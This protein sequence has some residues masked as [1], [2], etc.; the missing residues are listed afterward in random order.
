MWLILTDSMFETK[1]ALWGTPSGVY[2]PVQCTP[3]PHFCA[4]W[5][6]CCYG[7]HTNPFSANYPR[8]Q[9]ASS[10]GGRRFRGHHL[11]TWLHFSPVSKTVVHLFGHWPPLSCPL[12]PPH[13]GGTARM[14]GL[15]AGLFFVFLGILC[16]R[17]SIG[18]VDRPAVDNTACRSSSAC[19]AVPIKPVPG[20]PSPPFIN[21][22]SSAAANLSSLSRGSTAGPASL[23]GCVDYRLSLFDNDSTSWTKSSRS[24]FLRNSV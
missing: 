22:T 3:C 10:K 24:Q 8:T 5:L 14:F 23:C 21:P 17:V 13:V 9:S 6:L 19:E 1:H 12:Q 7:C 15:N 18:Q 2:Q 16:G 11:P 4:L 20:I